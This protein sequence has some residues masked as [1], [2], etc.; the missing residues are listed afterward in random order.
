LHLEGNA[1]LKLEG[2][3]KHKISLAIL[4]CLLAI[5]L[6]HAANPAAGSKLLVQTDWLAA[7]LSDSNVVVI[8][9]APSRAAYEAGH[10][11]GA[12][13]LPASDVAVTRNGVP[14]Q[15]PASDV[16]KSAFERVG[17]SNKSHVIL[18]GDMLGLFAARAYFALDYLGHGDH[19]ALLDGGLEKWKAEHRQ[20][21]TAVPVV[22]AGSLTVKPHSQLIA[23]LPSMQRIAGDKQAVLIDARPPEEYSGARPSDGVPRAGHIPGA[24]NV[25]WLENLVSKD[26]PVLKPLPEI[27]AKYEAAGARPGARVVV[28]CRTGI[29]ASHD[30][31]TL[32]L[33]GYRPIL[34]EG[35]FFEWS[36]APGTA[37][38]KGT[39]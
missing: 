21:S 25:F 15:L 17:V 6:G 33:L 1:G 5:G 27:L 36:N 26:N 4:I 22:Q 3:M 34:Y 18:Y 35:S 13:F 28:Y 11:P 19:A 7:H 2:I 16:L 23:D 9:V 8:H 12:R 32:K 37:V 20:V 10:I 24:R 14:N 29:Q 30:Y 38:E 39:R 31:F